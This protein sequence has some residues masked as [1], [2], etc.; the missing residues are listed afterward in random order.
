M[1]EIVALWIK[2]ARRLP[3]KSVDQ[4]E[5]IAGRG[6]EGN[7]DQGG[8]RQVTIIDECLARRR[9][10]VGYRSRSVGAARTS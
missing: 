5:L 6:I 4:A 7:A 9:G 8:W 10:G 1:G 2:P 3:M